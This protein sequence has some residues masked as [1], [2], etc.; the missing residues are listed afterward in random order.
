MSNIVLDG[1]LEQPDRG[2]GT[3]LFGPE[4]EDVDDGMLLDPPDPVDLLIAHTHAD[5]AV[6]MGS[7]PLDFV[8]AKMSEMKKENKRLKDRVA[9]LEQTLSIVQTAQ[10]WTLG[11]GMTQEQA[12]RMQEIKALLEQA[13]KAKEEMNAF[14]NSSRAA[15]YEKLRTCKAALRREKQEK[16]EMKDRLMHAFDHARAHRDAHRKIARQ[17]EEDHQMWNQA[18]KEVK[19]RSQLELR[20]LHGDPAA[21]QSERKD[22]LSHYGEQVMGD[23]SAL[24]QHLKGVRSETVDQVILEGDDFDE[25]KDY[26]EVY[27]A[28]GAF[29]STGELGA[30]VAG[31]A[32]AA[33]TD[34]FDDPPS[35]A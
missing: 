11:K 32:V 26:N 10:E 2:S 30:E 27:A 35:D 24:Q 29:G 16:A 6:N 5:E 15:L 22:Q 14:S 3:G 8:R 20:R 9:D 18:L 19:E 12:M 31:D 23:L 28:T 13:K 4:F 33:G 17:R 7:K 1:T 25:E 34:G 21:I